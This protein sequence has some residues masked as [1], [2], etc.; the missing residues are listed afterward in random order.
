MGNVKISLSNLRSNNNNFGDK[1][2]HRFNCVSI[3]FI[4]EM[5]RGNLCRIIDLMKRG[6]RKSFAIMITTKSRS[7]LQ[8]L[9]S[10]ISKGVWHAHLVI[11]T[12]KRECPFLTK[13]MIEDK[14]RLT[15]CLMYL[16]S[17]CKDKS[18]SFT[19]YCG[20]MTFIH[21]NGK[22]Y[23]FNTCDWLNIL[24]PDCKSYVSPMPTGTGILDLIY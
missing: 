9:K 6:C 10:L 23:V 17:D 11:S 18:L 12:C 5:D 1:M 20:G 13:E 14:T 2:Q 4:S 15:S 7:E 22:N 3:D 21:R 19:I 16:S 8:N 24:G